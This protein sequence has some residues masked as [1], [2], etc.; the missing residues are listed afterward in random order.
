MRR[1]ILIGVAIVAGGAAAAAGGVYWFLS[2][3]GVR[4]AFERQATAW[5]GQP[6]AIG[7]ASAR[8][9]P[10]PAIALGDVRIGSPARVTLANVQLS[11]GLRPLLSRRIEDAA[12]VISNSRIDL[13]L[14]FD[15][16]VSPSGSSTKATSGGVEVA[17][18]RA[19]ALRD[20]TITSRGRQIQISADSSLSSAHLSLER[21]TASS[22]ATTL[23]ASGLAQ[24]TPD[25][26][27]QLQVRA[28]RVD[29]DD[30][31]VLA[32]AFT[33]RAPA[34][35]RRTTSAPAFPGHLVAR[36]SAESARTG[37]LEVGQFATTVVAQGGRFTLS[38]TTF[39]LFGGR[40]EGAIEVAL[41]STL[42]ATI[43]S[44]ITD[45]DVAQ[46]AEFGGVPGAISGRLTGAGTFTGRGA[47]VAAA[48]AAASGDGT[49]TISRG[50]V[51][52]LGLVRTVVLFFGRPAPSAG[53][54]SDAFDRI[55]ASFS[56]ARQVVT[57]SALSLHSADLDL[58][59]QGTLDVADKRL[60]GHADL[61]L[62]EALSAQAGS[63]LVRF[64]RD[65][66]RVLLPA[67]IGGTLDAPRVSI[68]AAAAARRGLRNEV[69]RRLGGI[70]GGR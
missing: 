10:R 45:L 1:Y 14:P 6:V 42:R 8:L 7:A 52:R 12:V 56:L 25:V 49:A 2:G 27:V 39:Q 20:I 54:S 18:V 67:T 13:P 4:L 5:L 65:G 9:F 16:P 32:D 47:T 28:N 24:L 69:Q 60:D 33:P 66:N 31:L 58:V 22:G 15:L 70:L 50:E 23:E 43:T 40:Y 41:D 63:D 37:A 61:S 11:T 53:A 46:L 36:V 64:T 62:S 59:A 38:R 48:I 34:A 30:L 17:S 35:A 55:D 68:D 19:I 51:K 3:D 57:A 21:F 29:I 44:R 26:D